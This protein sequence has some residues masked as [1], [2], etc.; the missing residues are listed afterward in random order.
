MRTIEVGSTSIEKATEKG[1]MLL[2]TTIENV[3]IKMS[4]VNVTVKDLEKVDFD[5]LK[6]LNMGI[7]VVGNVVKCASAEFVA[8]VESSLNK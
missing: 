1:L 4:R 6:E 3:E 2:E 5:K 8:A 7:L